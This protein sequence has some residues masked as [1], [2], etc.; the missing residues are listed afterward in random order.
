MRETLDSIKEKYH[1][2]VG[3]LENCKGFAVSMHSFTP[4]W[5]KQ[6]ERNLFE[7]VGKEL[8]RFT[9]VIKMVRK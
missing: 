8:Q 9:V 5:T 2:A 1:R 7:P 6:R 4:E 3:E